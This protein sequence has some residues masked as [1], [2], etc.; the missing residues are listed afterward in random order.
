MV[1]GSFLLV[2]IEGRLAAPATGGDPD[3]AAA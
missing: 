2:I 1:M 3:L